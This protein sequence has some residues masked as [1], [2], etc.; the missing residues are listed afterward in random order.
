M[1]EG[2][3]KHKRKNQNMRIY[4]AGEVIHPF[5]SD[6]QFPVRLYKHRL[7]FCDKFFQIPLLSLLPTIRVDC[8]IYPAI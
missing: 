1:T 6:E 2:K 7:H 4:L 8:T 3:A 5:D